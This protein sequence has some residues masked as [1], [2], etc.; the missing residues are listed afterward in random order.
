MGRDAVGYRRAKSFSY[1]V[2]KRE[3]E[4]GITAF[5]T[6]NVAES[7]ASCPLLSTNAESKMRC[8]PTALM[9]WSFD[10]F[11]VQEE[12][13]FITETVVRGPSPSF[14]NSS[15][16]LRVHSQ[17]ISF[18]TIR[19]ALQQVLP[20]SIRFHPLSPLDFV[21]CA[22]RF[23]WIR[24]KKEV[25]DSFL[26]NT[27]VLSTREGYLF[28]GGI[29]SIPVPASQK[30]FPLQMLPDFTYT[31]VLRN[32][33]GCLADVL[34]P[35]RNICRNGFLNYSHSARH[36]MSI[37]Q[38]FDD[39]KLLLGRDYTTFLKHFVKSLSET[40]PHVSRE[41]SSLVDLLHDG[42]TICS[43]WEGMRNAIRRAVAADRP[44]FHRY[45]TGLYQHH[46]TVLLDLTNRASDLFPKHRDPAV[47]IR[48]SI[49]DLILKEKMRAISDVVF[50]IVASFRWNSFGSRVVV[51]DLVVPSCAKADA[52]GGWR[53]DIF[54]GHADHVGGW[55]SSS[56]EKEWISVAEEQGE[57]T[58]PRV[59]LI[60]SES[61]AQ[62]YTIHDVVLPL[63]G[64]GFDELHLPVN[65]CE[66]VLHQAIS[67]LR[68]EGFPKMSLAPK[69]SY[70]NIFRRTLSPSSFYIV[71]EKRG[72]EWVDN[73]ASQSLKNSLY[74]DQENVLR[75]KSSL[76]SFVKR[77]NIA[78]P[79]ISGEISRR[80]YLKP[81]N[82]SG[83]TCIL[84][85]KL[86]R[87]TAV[88]TVLREAFRTTNFPVSGICKLLNLH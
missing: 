8:R 80:A 34:D 70:R 27:R 45:H 17:G 19:K 6:S 1:V 14:D 72:W 66:E 38:V 88:A 82:A 33:S 2:Q 43:E 68:L 69:A 30:F 59:K 18:P 52:E 54:E 40:T 3:E 87:G 67:E 9:K 15:C 13:P 84:R 53:G 25:V 28:L 22:S 50:N 20:P 32:I 57:L 35:L 60:R 12:L 7:S 21:S 73:P 47:V 61:E 81:I 85:A 42:S 86:P 26:E 71:D 62:G 83:A 75:I 63:L 5:S 58:H 4:I 76:D 39:A 79:G 23:I 11:S 74:K 77:H 29:V 44:L 36:G 10:D 24:E 65:G 48:E 51:G 56:T 49:T 16:L 37:L 41:I 46:H 31:V 64:R 55:F 78:R